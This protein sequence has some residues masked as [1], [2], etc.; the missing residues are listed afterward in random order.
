MKTLIFIRLLI[1]WDIRNQQVFH[2]KI[3]KKHACNPNMCFATSNDR[4]YQK[5]IQNGIQMGDP[6]SIKNHKNPP[7]DLPGSL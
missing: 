6:K 4:T 7:W 1:S 5:V 2:S 3:I